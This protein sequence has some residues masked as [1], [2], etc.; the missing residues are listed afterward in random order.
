MQLLA[1]L[2]GASLQWHT[3][4]RLVYALQQQLIQ[5]LSNENWDSSETS[6]VPVTEESAKTCLTSSLTSS[7][8]ARM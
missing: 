1:S 6:K 4:L 2:R 7:S 8:C 5:Q 3:V